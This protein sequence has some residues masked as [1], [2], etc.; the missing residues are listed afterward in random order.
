MEL[1]ID[2]RTCIESTKKRILLLGIANYLVKFE[3]QIF[4]RHNDGDGR[5]LPIFVHKLA[6]NSKTGEIFIADNNKNG[7][8]VHDLRRGQTKLLISD[9]IGNVTAMAFGE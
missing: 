7:I 9:D 4:G 6:Y 1:N 2:Q 5:T 3:H 8:Y